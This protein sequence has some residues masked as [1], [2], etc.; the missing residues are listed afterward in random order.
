MK[1]ATGR[2]VSCFPLTRM[3]EERQKDMCILTGPFRTKLKLPYQS[4]L[5]RGVPCSWRMCLA[6]LLP[7]RRPAQDQINCRDNAQHCYEQRTG[8]ETQTKHTI[9]Q[10]TVELYAI[11]M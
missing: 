9:E 10:R 4:Y 8:Y 3:G 11:I 2:R 7:V 1:M 6:V 5:I